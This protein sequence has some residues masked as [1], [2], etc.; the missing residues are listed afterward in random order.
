MSKNPQQVSAAR[1]PVD[2]PSASGVYETAT[3]SPETRDEIPQ[4]A[5]PSAVPPRAP[6]DGWVGRSLGRYEITGVLGEGGMGV[7]LKARDRMIER[8]VA[9]KVLAGH[10]ASNAIALDRFLAEAKAAGKLN[11]PNVTAIYEIGQENGIYFLVLEFVPGGSLSQ[12][13]QK[14]EPISVIEATEVLIDAC[15]GVG[16]A[17]AA[18]LIHRDIKPANFLRAADGSTKVADFGIAKAVAD[19]GKQMTHSGQ[20]LGTPWYMSPEQCEGKP[21]D[22]R[23]DLYSLGATYYTLLTGKAPYHETDGV[24]RVMF[25]HC[26]GPVPDPRS[27][28]PAI[29]DACSR[30]VARAM[31]KAPDDRYQSAGAM[32]ADLQAVLKELS[33]PGASN[34]DL[35]SSKLEGGRSKIEACRKHIS[36]RIVAPGRTGHLTALHLAAVGKAAPG[37][38]RR[39][40]CCEARWR[41]DQGRSAAVALRYHGE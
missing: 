22:H 35:R 24:I 28:N 34:S 8:D 29:P 4:P 20:I 2:S 26:E 19:N 21:L 6:M 38:P 40:G 11:H 31:A 37:S 13:L 1:N 9:I 30:I 27:V 16:A 12:R 14:P 39:A 3:I 36:T 41:S 25:L 23:T 17:H 18:G 10:L 15:K 32:L 7:V 33:D 5:P